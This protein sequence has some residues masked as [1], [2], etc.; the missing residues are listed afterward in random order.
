MNVKTALRE[1]L[2]TLDPIQGEGT[3]MAKVPEV[4][5]AVGQRLA[6]LRKDKGIS[7][8]EIARRLEVT[9]PLVSGWERGASRLNSET[10]LRLSE[11]LEVSTDELL[12]LGKATQQKQ[13]G[14]TRRI[15]KR[16]H[17][18][19]RLPKRDQEALLRTIDAFLDRAS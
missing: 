4:H 13:A 17:A 14:Q 1:T 19:T 2:P 12:G 16:I 8:R 15:A 7:Q 9:Q 3:G 11:I 5:E 18:I 10:I 6:R